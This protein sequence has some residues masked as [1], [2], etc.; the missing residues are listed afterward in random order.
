MANGSVTPI[1]R[2]NFPFV[3]RVQAMAHV[4]WLPPF[5]V[6]I[7]N[8]W[9]VWRLFFIEY[10]DQLPSVEGEFIAMARY[11]QSHWP[12]YD[13]QSLWLGGFPVVRTYQPLVHYGVATLS[14]I[15]GLSPA[16]AFHL[17]GAASYSLGGLA[18][19]YLAKT[20]SGSHAVALCG[21]L[22]FSL[23][24]P[25]N[26]LIPGVRLDA[27]GLLNARRLHALVVYGELP[28]LTGP[29]AGNVRTCNDAPCSS[30]A[31]S[32]FRGSGRHFPR[33]RASDQLAVHRRPFD[34]RPLLSD[35]PL[36]E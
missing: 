22:C 35:S 34:C 9:V 6:L 26:A 24:S 31:N 13:W 23:F 36:F 25:S 18:F 5:I 15:S 33:S 19:Y 4:S 21:G 7:V 8:V 16:A 28:N 29:H 20:L 30:A 12:A 11:I 3:K 27:G 1:R 17:F 32:Q 14:S 2:T 10:L